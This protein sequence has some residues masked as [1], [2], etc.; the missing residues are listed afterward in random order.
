MLLYIYVLYIVHTIEVVSLKRNKCI[1]EN[2]KPKQR[3][4]LKTY[5]Q[6]PQPQLQ[7]LLSVDSAQ[8]IKF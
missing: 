2:P 5:L 8:K 6:E 4:N 3:F 1:T 7:L